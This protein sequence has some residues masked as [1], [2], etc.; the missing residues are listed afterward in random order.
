MAASDA[1][2]QAFINAA[3]DAAT[4]RWEYQQTCLRLQAEWNALDYGTALVQADFT[5]D[6]E[7]ITPAQIGAVVFDTANLDQATLDVGSATNIARIK[8]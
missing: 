7:G 5:G 1:Q 4:K 2:K 8:R 3:R 6:N